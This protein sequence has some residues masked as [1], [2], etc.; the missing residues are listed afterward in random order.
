MKLILRKNGV[1]SFL[2]PTISSLPIKNINEIRTER[3]NILSIFETYP[4][5]N[6][7]LMNSIQ[8]YCNTFLNIKLNTKIGKKVLPIDQYIKLLEDHEIYLC[9]SYQEGGPLPAMDAMQNGLV[10]ISTPVGQIQDLI[11]NGLNGYICK[12]KDEF[13]EKITLLA[14]DLKSLHKMRLKSLEYINKFRNIKSIKTSTLQFTNNIFLSN[15]DCT[16]N[17]QEDIVN[18]INYLPLLI[19]SSFFNI[20]EFLEIKLWGQFI[21]KV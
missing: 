10:V 11:I 18:F 9:T 20:K 13:L 1:E 2:L 15:K 5:K 8:N 7:S 6:I 3:C 17:R 16:Y 19:L 21:R 12:T 14:N 4:R